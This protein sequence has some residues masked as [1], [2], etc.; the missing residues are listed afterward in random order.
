LNIIAQ[1]LLDKHN[2]YQK[3]AQGKSDTS[4]LDVEKLPQHL[5]EKYTP[6]IGLSKSYEL[7]CD[8]NDEIGKKIYDVMKKRM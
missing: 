5:K 2:I 3:Y 4:K 7:L 1:V 8:L 6:A